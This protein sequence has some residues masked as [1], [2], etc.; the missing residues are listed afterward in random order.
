[1]FSHGKGSGGIKKGEELLLDYGEAYWE[2]VERQK[3]LQKIW[4]AG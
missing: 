3:L 2:S 1:M 4:E